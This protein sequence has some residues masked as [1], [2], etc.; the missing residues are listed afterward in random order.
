MASVDKFNIT[1]KGIGGHA[2]IPHNAIDPIVMASQYT[3]SLQKIIARRIS[4]FHNAV[5]SVT[6]IHGGNTWNVIPDTVTP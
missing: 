3:L 1:F 5:I 2:G 6:S 4:L